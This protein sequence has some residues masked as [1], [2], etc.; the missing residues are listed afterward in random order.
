MDSWSRP[1][2]RVLS[3]GDGPLAG[4]DQVVDDADFALGLPAV[5]VAGAEVCAPQWDPAGGVLRAVRRLPPVAA[6]AAATPPWVLPPL[7]WHLLSSSST[8]QHIPSNAH[9][10]LELHGGGTQWLYAA[11]G[12]DN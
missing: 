1:G 7:H 5:I 3:A 10:C 12:M 9:T 4:H 2:A 6:A 8:H 11:A